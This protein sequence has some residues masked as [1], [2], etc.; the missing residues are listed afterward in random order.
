MITIENDYA[1]FIC[2]DVDFKEAD[3]IVDVNG[4]FL[5]QTVEAIRDD[6][7]LIKFS[8]DKG[9]V[10]FDSGNFQD[11]KGVVTPIKRRASN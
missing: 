8:D 2:D 5:K 10:I 9:P 6:K 1:N 4:S 11:Q 3:F 7:L